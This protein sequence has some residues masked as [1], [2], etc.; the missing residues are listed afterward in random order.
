VGLSVGPEGSGTGGATSGWIPFDPATGAWL[1]V[2]QGG[3]MPTPVLPPDARR[4]GVG[5]TLWTVLLGLDMGLLGLAL[6]YSAVVVFYPGPLPSGN[7]G[8]LDQTTLWATVLLN[9]ITLAL[10]PLAWVMGTRVVPWE[11]TELYLRL[12]RPLQGIG[13][14]LLWGIATLGGLI[15]LGLLLQ[16][17]HYQ[18]S[19]PQAKDILDTVT[20]PLAFILALSAGIGE[21]IFFRGLLQKRLGWVGQAIVFG[22]FHLS[23]GTPLQVII[24]ALL[25][26]LYGWLIRRGNSLWVTM[27]AHFVFDFVQLSANYWLPPSLR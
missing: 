18:P 24:P 5:P 25:G 15:V 11:G 20:L 3:A 2:P 10:I 12:Q 21:E 7:S 26:L 17:F 27:T 19:N 8:N 16:A 1:P 14:G 9:T 6:I 13:K 23:Y 4:H 22:L